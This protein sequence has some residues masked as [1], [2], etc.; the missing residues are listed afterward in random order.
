MAKTVIGEHGFYKLDYPCFREVYEDTY[1]EDVITDVHIDEDPSNSLLNLPNTCEVAESGILPVFYN[2]KKGCY[3]DETGMIVGEKSLVDGVKAFEVGESVKVLCEKGEPQCVIG[4]ASHV[5]RMCADIFK[6][7]IRAWDKMDYYVYYIG[8]LAG[9]YCGLSR[10]DSCSDSYGSSLNLACTE[11]GY[12]LF[13]QHEFQRG[14]TVNYWG[15]LFVKVGPIMYILRIT[16]I[17]A[18]R[19][20]TGQM[21]LFGAIWNEELE[22]ECKRLGAAA[23]HTITDGV[24]NP[25]PTQPV[26]PIEL[27]TQKIFTKTFTDR[28]SLSW[29]KLPQPRWF[30]TELWGQQ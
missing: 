25:L 20:L 4:H 21:S 15:D 12:K 13:G 16:S 11:K 23:E 24:F 7:K 27:K 10:E 26:Y 30:Y 8:G 9:E 22:T 1:I 5:P 28:F 2:C 18:P 17:G 14:A 29:S 19:P 3:T 6:M